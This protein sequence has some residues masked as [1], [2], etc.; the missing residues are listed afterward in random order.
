[1]EA[2]LEVVIRDR[3]FDEGA[4]RKAITAQAIRSPR[5]QRFNTTT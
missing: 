1:M 5:R 4:G 3:A 2:A